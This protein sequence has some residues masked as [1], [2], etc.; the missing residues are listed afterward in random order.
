MPKNTTIENQVS[1]LLTRCQSGDKQ[2]RDELFQVLYPELKRIAH[3]KLLYSKKHITLQ[4][5]ELINELYIRLCKS[6]SF[7]SKNK[8]YFFAAAATAI[9]Q[10]I[11]DYYRLKNRLRRGGQ[12]QRVE[13]DEN[14]AEYSEKNDQDLLLLGQLMQQL[15]TIDPDCAAV[16]QLKLLAGLKSTE[17][18]EALGLS[19]RTVNR[20]WAF[21]KSYLN[22]HL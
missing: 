6:R 22:F 21:A 17:A 5:T 9:E 2:A 7:P 20:K 15:K 16:A 11:I 12:M 14:S 10:I 8:L 3:R 1:S 18:A 4:S 13:L 19:I